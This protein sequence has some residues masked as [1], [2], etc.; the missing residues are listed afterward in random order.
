LLSEPI[1]SKRRPTQSIDAKYSIPF[2]C[3]V[4]MAKGNVTLR[5]YTEEGLRDPE[6]LAMADRVS[7]RPAPEF[8]TSYRNP[9]VEVRT[10]DGRVLTRQASAIPGD[11]RR[12]LSRNQV[13][14]KFRECLLFS[15][16]PVAAANIDRAIRLIDNLEQVEDAT[17]I[18]RLL[19]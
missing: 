2:T 4:A 15:A 19:T 7:Y 18:V 3:A 14:A 12:P 8:D 16:T 13:E 9:A 5:A 1:E 6:V 10:R 11:A 17:E